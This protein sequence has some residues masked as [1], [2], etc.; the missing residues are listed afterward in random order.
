M[1]AKTDRTTESTRIPGLVDLQVNGYKGVDFSGRELTEEDFA[2]SCRDLLAAGT[3]AFLPTLITSP[4][5][6]YERNLPIM[7]AVMQQDE[8]QGRVLGIHLEGPF[9]SAQEGARGAHNPAWMSDPDVESLARL[10][11]W[12]GGT[13]RL[14]TIAADL[15]GA[16]EL[17]RYATSQGITVSL[18]HHMADEEDLSRLVD[19][20]A[21]AL[22]HLGNG[23]P[24]MLCRHQNPVW[25]G[26]ANDD[27][28]ALI[29][30]DGHHL[31]PSLLKTILRTKGPD[32]CIVVSDASPLAGLPAGQYQSM[33]ARVV[34]EE[35][36]LLHNPATGYMA[37]SSA[38]IRT[39]A[40]HLASL[41]LVS[42][43]EIA[44]MVWDNPL[45][46]IGVSPERVRTDSP[47]AF[48]VTSPPKS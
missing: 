4:M 6:L 3:T 14:L 32:K 45:Q 9:L 29:I 35:S 10:L 8:F 23:V 41:D 27:L 40:A 21:R 22:T 36:G 15:D 39:C 7:A 37:G 16:E 25:A 38:T 5:E 17:A 42:P 47:A 2:R 18:G 12:A 28:A 33:G 20:G 34:L 30:A 19:A 13:V 26:L 11:E 48:D 1:E 43:E 31:P 24:A 46:L 44:R